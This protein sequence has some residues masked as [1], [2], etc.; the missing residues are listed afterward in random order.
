M[1]SQGFRVFKGHQGFHVAEVVVACTRPGVTRGV[2][3]L[4]ASTQEMSMASKPVQYPIMLCKSSTAGGLELPSISGAVRWSGG[5]F[6]SAWSCQV[7]VFNAKGLSTPGSGYGLVI[8]G[9]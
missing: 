3:M 4:M 5:A 7:C 1:V 9:R 6:D 2:H 8:P